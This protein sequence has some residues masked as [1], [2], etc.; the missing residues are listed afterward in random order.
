ML[1]GTSWFALSAC[2]AKFWDRLDHHLPTNAKGAQAFY[3]K[4]RLAA[5]QGQHPL[6][7][8]DPVPLPQGSHHRSPVRSVQPA[9]SAKEAAQVAA[10]DSTAVLAP[11][12]WSD[13]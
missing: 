12:S 9:A 7:A 5:E 10:W 13:A 2:T 3:S 8:P 11:V 1:L 4:A 6:P